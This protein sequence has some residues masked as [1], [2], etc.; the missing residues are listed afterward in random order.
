MTTAIVTGASRG[1]GL[2]LSTVLAER[3]VH[4]IGLARPARL[5]VRKNSGY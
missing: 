5:A 1:I 3:G 4:V 2:A